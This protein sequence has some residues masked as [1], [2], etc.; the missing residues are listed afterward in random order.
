MKRA[1]HLFD[2]SS[3]FFTYLCTVLNR[4]AA[5]KVI[6]IL[7]L[8]FLVS[9]LLRYPNLNRPLSKHHEFVTAIPLRVLQIWQKEGASKFNFNPVMNYKGEANKFINNH[10]STTG[11]V[12]DKEGNYYYVSHPQ[13]AYIFPYLVFKIFNIKATVLSIQVFHLV[14]NFFSAAFIYL[15]IC[16]LSIQKPFK[17]LFIPGFIG[18]VVYLFSP[19]VLWFQSNTYMSDMLVQLPFILAV[20]TILKLLMRKRFYSTKYLLYY[21]LF[22]FL[23]IYTSWL[24]VFF[25]FAVFVYSIIK[26]RYQK[27]FI[28]LIFVTIGVS[29]FTLFLIFKQYSLINGSEAYIVQMYQRFAVRGSLHGHSFLSFIYGKLI[30][31]KAILF[32]YITSYLPIFILLVSFAWLSISKSKMKFVFTKNGI[33]FLWLSTL[34][35]LFLHFVLMN[36]SGHDF[37]SLYG[38]LFLSVVIGILYDKLKRSKIISPYFLNGGILATVVLSVI[39]YYAI[40]LPGTHSI[41]GDLYATSMNIGKFIKKDA[42]ENERIYIAGDFVLDPQLIVYAERNMIKISE[43][44]IDSVLIKDKSVCYLIQKDNKIK[45]L[46]V[47]E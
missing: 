10:S 46:R 39:I 31:L 14:V 43:E 9:V 33:R 32:S 12:I 25:A 18:F 44:K 27:V 20:Y 34:P 35:V 16:L 13:F 3:L 45:A 29:V 6:S 24:G 42:K 47:F 21:A 41:K 26:L 36:Y 40:N 5:I 22:L 15:I 19:G 38:S 2:K 17:R 8:V 37:V 1:Y 4:S 30:E 11:T 7:V 23:M 28:P